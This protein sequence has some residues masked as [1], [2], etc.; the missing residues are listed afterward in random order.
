MILKMMMK[1]KHNYIIARA[2]KR[3][4]ML[5]MKDLKREEMDWI[6]GMKK[7]AGRLEKVE[8]PAKYEQIITV[9]IN[10]QYNG[11]ELSFRLKPDASERAKLK[12]A[13]YKWHYKKMVWYATNTPGRVAMI[14]DLRGTIQYP[15]GWISPDEKQDKTSESLTDYM[16]QHA[17][18]ILQRVARDHADFMD[19]DAEEQNSVYLKEAE[20]MMKSQA[21]A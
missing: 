4:E 16:K 7:T 11:I 13:G 1:L 2:M 12:R 17:G 18:E 9:S 5:K 3:R 15:D 21:A 6:D 10:K 19:L 14:K 20:A 8:K